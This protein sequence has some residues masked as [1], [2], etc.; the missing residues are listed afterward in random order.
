[1]NGEVLEDEV[2]EAEFRQIKGHFERTLQVSCCERDPEF[3]SMAK[4]NLITRALVNQ[5]SV[6]H[7]PEVD[8]TEAAQRLARLKEEAGG[9]QQF[10]LRIGVPVADDA[11][12]LPQIESGVRVDKLL[13]HINGA[14]DDP[15]DAEVRAYY[16]SHTQDFLSEEQI[17]ACHISKGLE[18]AKSRAEVYQRMREL[19]REVTAGTDFMTVADRERGEAQQQIDLGWF[20]RGEFMEEF[21]TIAFSMEEG[22]LSP[23]F[24]TQLGFHLCKLM[25]KRSPAP[26]PFY[27]IRDAVKTRLID[28]SRD[29]KFNAFVA[30]LRATASIEDTDPDNLNGGH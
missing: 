18:G 8:P 30:D 13:S 28:E 25:G 6:K 1:V 7:F 22:E 12:V 20:R 27:E 15:T 19:R 23:V 4:E 21:E 11:L 24:T 17:H 10:F 9:E 26:L 3:L 2:I 29:A 16:E 5:A 14:E